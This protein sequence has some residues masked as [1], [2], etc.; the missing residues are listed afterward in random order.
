MVLPCG[1]GATGGAVSL[2]RFLPNF[3]FV[4]VSNVA[5]AVVVV[6]LPLVAFG[7]DGAEI[8]VDEL[9]RR[10]ALSQLMRIITKSGL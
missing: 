3:F 5:V 8:R 4:V 7:A 9:M 10:L 1:T 6:L 2:L